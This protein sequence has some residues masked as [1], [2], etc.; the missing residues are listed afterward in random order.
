LKER[1]LKNFWNSNISAFTR[2]ARK[3][4]NNDFEIAKDALSQAF[5]S[6][7]VKFSEETYREELQRRMRGWVYTVIRRRIQSYFRDR[8]TQPYSSPDFEYPAEK[9]DFEPSILLTELTEDLGRLP[10]HLREAIEIMDL[11]PERP[12]PGDA[13]RKMGCSVA[14]LYRRHGEAEAMLRKIIN[15]GPEGK[16]D[17]KE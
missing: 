13:A 12:S 15:D 7:W 3:C 17:D 16:S 5:N 1:E 11:S 6:T 4:A 8:R 14:T 10:A 2:F 9:H